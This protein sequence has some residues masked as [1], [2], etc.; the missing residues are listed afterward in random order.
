MECGASSRRFPLAHATANIA[1]IVAALASVLV[2]TV[3]AQDAPPLADTLEK[4]RTRHSI[5]ALAAAA[6][7]EEKIIAIEAVGF[8]KADDRVPVTAEDQWHIGSCTKSMT[9]TLAAMLVEDGQIAWTT[10]IDAVFPELADAMEPAW[11]RVTLAHLLTHRAGLPTAPPDNLWR[12]AWRAIGTP[13][14]Q[15]REF[16]QGL[17]LRRPE[18]A[19]GEKFTYSNQGYAIAGAMLER[20][21]GQPWETLMRERLFTP[22]GMKSAG[23]GAPAVADKIDQPWGHRLMAG[24]PMPV[25]PAG[26]DSD[27][28]AAIGPGGTVHCSIGDL[29]RYAG[30]HA[31]SIRTTARILGPAS[32]EK[33]HTPPP[34]GDYA[35]GWRV[36]SRDWAGGTA[37]T[38]NG[39][40]TMWY[41]VMW[42]A[43]EK[44]SA[45]VAATN[46]AGKAAEQACDE[47]VS[48]L[49]QSTLK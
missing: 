18:S 3:H 39:S 30:W 27:N 48:A 24:S 17:L 38:H 11:Q 33:L 16:V 36:V 28:P 34:G 4:I 1:G 35:M 43:P 41:A 47:A 49:I 23:F 42:L 22:L 26:K 14:E 31:R 10:T 15:R 9:A 7:R 46:V 40:N 45:F 32:F 44:G 25:S 37:L 8:R 5:P 20:A 19:P 6:V 13:T 29:A 21:T 12:N 2:C